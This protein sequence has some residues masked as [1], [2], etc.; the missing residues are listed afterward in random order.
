MECQKEAEFDI[1]GQSGFEDNTQA[2]EEHVGVLLGTPDW[3][4]KE[5][6]EWTVVLIR[7]RVPRRNGELE[8]PE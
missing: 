5:T 7:E 2:C 1:Y 3:A 8:R 4:K 6:T